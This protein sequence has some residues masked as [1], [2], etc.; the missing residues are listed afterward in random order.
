MHADPLSMREGTIRDAD[1]PR[2]PFQ[3]N[4]PP[5]PVDI[6]RVAMQDV[7]NDPIRLLQTVVEQQVVGPQGQTLRRWQDDICA[8]STPTG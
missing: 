8:R 5:L 3:S 2:V 6:D 4:D 1:N 7:I